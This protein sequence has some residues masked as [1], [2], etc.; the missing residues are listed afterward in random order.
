MGK[1]LPKER[2]ERLR[3][4]FTRLMEKYALVMEDIQA[5]M[6]HTGMQVDPRTLYRWIHEGKGTKRAERVLTMLQTHYGEIPKPPSSEEFYDPFTAF[7]KFFDYVEE[8]KRIQTLAI[9]L[10]GEIT[11]ITHRFTTIAEFLNRK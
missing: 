2:Q 11:K 3:Q 6:K 4:E 1:G 7:A 5:V 8:L 9:N 10:Q